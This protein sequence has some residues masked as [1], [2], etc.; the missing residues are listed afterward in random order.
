[1][2]KIG[3]IILSVMLFA[4]G[5]QA[6]GQSLMDLLNKETI[7]NV[8]GTVVEELDVI[9]ANI[10]GRWSYSGIAVRLTGDDMLTNAASAL[11]TGQIEEKLNGYLEQIGLRQ[12]TFSYTFSADSTFS[13]SFGKLDFPGTYTFSSEDDSINLDYGKNGRLG[14]VTMEAEAKISLNSMELLFN[15]D[16]L[17]DFIEKISA[18]AGDSGLGTIGSLLGQYD[19]IRIGFELTRK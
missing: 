6:Y 9:P 16:K 15:A 14:G 17:L 1:M 5:T 7:K 11:A 3:F 12:D 10:E 8:V 2:K 4:A 13:T 19:G 18:V